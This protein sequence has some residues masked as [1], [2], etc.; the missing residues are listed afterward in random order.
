MQRKRKQSKSGLSRNQSSRMPDNWGVFTTLNQMT[1]NSNPIMNNARWKLE[2][3]MPAAMRCKAPVDGCGE[4][5][6]S[7]GKRKTKYACIV[8]TDESIRIRLEGVPQRCHKD[9]IT[10]KG[11]NPLSHYNFVHK[12][13][14][15]PQAL[16]ILDAKNI[17]KRKGKTW[18]YQ[19]GSWQKWETRKRW[20]MKQG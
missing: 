14:P 6:R 19:H 4:T 20:S 13:I 9:H 1:K 18:E 10:A 2:V 17:G 15:M 12:F 3:P 7:I 11:V 16:K 5:C 8:D